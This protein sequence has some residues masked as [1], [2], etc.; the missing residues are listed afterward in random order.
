MLSDG[1]SRAR[2]RLS[3]GRGKSEERGR[4]KEEGGKGKVEFVGVEV[5]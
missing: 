1:R 5:A 2:S 4:R 3:G